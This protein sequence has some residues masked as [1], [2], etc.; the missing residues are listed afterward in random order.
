MQKESTILNLWSNS[1][2]KLL[3]QKRKKY[4]YTETLSH[5]HQVKGC[6]QEKYRQTPGSRVEKKITVEGLSEIDVLQADVKYD[7]FE[8]DSNVV[9]L[10]IWPYN[11]N[12][13]QNTERGSAGLGVLRI[14]CH[15]NRV[16]VT[17]ESTKMR[18]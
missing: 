10:E 14:F 15:T 18:M 1:M 17:P 7:I 16:K 3:C 9:T 12:M 5:G 13:N 2:K 8:N 4:F 11:V 6:N